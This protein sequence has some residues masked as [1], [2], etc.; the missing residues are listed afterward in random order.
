MPPAGKPYFGPNNYNELPPQGGLLIVRHAARVPILVPSAAYTTGLTRAGR[1]S[2]RAYG[3]QLAQVFRLGQAVASPAPR[4]LQTAKEIAAGMLD[5]SG[6]PRK[7]LP[8]EALHFDQ[9]LTG[10]PGLRGVYLNDP[11]FLEL[12]NHPSAPEYHLLRSNLLASLPF[13]EQPGVLNLAATHDV[14][15]TFLRASLLGLPGATLQDFP[16]FLEGVCLVK[17]NGQVRLW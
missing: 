5:G 11:G 9:R 8:L 2:A 12:V 15:V 10:I 4:C 3:A 16:A 17:E 13:P 14:V 7:V 1:A 6:P